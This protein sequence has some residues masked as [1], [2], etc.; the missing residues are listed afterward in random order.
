MKKNNKNKNIFIDSLMAEPDNRLIEQTLNLLKKLKLNKN[1]SVVKTK[2]NKLENWY[3]SHP[4]GNLKHQSNRFFSIEALKY[5]NKFNSNIQP[6]INQKEIGILGI[7]CQRQLGTLKFLLQAKFEPGNKN[8]YQLSPTIQATK[9]NIERV[10]GGKSQKY[11]KYFL[12]KKSKVHFSILLSEQG[13]KFYNKKNKNI[14]IEA[15]EN[16]HIPVNKEFVWLTLSEIKVLI[17][18]NNIV[19]MST[20][21]VLSCLNLNP[22]VSCN[23]S[24][25]DS[26]ILNKKDKENVS[27]LKSNKLFSLCKK[28]EISLLTN[29]S[30]VPWYYDQKS[31]G[32]KKNNFFIQGIKVKSNTR[33][34]NSW[35]QPILKPINQYM[36][37]LFIRMI[38]GRYNFLLDIK[39]EPGIIKNKILIPT[40]AHLKN[41]KSKKNLSTLIDKFNGKIINRSIQS[42]EGGRFYLAQN[43]YIIVELPNKKKIDTVRNKIWLPI[44]QI[45]LLIRTSNLVGIQLRTFFSLINFIK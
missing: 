41:K 18:K 24:L 10:H 17:S 37:I 1:I 43:E 45:L 14:L 38:D 22:I 2:I 8:T 21:S 9:S 11:Y 36:Y 42:E 34:I 40:F 6:I 15:S 5:K 4:S 32:A 33:E 12:N 44:S 31:R 28:N 39:Y 13:T 27:S 3:I 7:I 30:S 23:F 29:L 19:N 20:R 16:K 25:L 26:L 35:D